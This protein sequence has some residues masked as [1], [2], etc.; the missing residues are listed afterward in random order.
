M[1][2]AKIN[3][4]ELESLLKSCD[5]FM[6]GED[7]ARKMGVTRAAVQKAVGR[8]K[9]NGYVVE[10]SRSKGYR[11]ISSPDLCMSDLGAFLSRSGAD[12]HDLFYF[13]TVSST[14]IL[15]MD[16]AEQ[17]CHEGTVVIADTQTSGKG[18]LGRSWLS[19]AARNLYMSLVVRPAIPPGDA[20]ALTLLS[21][22]ACSMAIANHCGLPVSIKWPNDL[23]A[24]GRKIGGILA[25]I[26]A[27]IDRIYHAVVG[28]GI[29]V[30]LSSAEIPDEI[31]K[32]ATSVLIET[33]S[34]TSRSG[35]AAEIITE[36]DR[37]YSLLLSKGKK[38]IIKK[39]SELCSTT[40][41]RVNISVGDLIIG[42]T[43]EGVDDDGLLIL[44]LDDGSLR[45][46]SAGDVTMGGAG[47]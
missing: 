7:I 44:R 24:N 2:K 1:P 41:R 19:P 31:N 39:W 32:T 14:N 10:A 4:G 27:D 42:G 30:N 40:G 15:A 23:I 34:R 16:M 35:L 25:E 9:K 12:K 43:A 28:I 18:R 26:R 38:A 8:L 45:R 20:T 17:G 37:W 29:N 21:A 46:F 6:S 36:F 5:G 13:D 3:T 47:Q 11:L 33:G 22:G